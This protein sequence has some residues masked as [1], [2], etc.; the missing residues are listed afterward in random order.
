[1][2][3]KGDGEAGREWPGEAVDMG[4]GGEEILEWR[5]EAL[6]C[7]RQREWEECGWEELEM[8]EEEAMETKLMGA[9][10]M[11]AVEMGAK[12]ANGGTVMEET[13]V[14]AN[15]QKMEGNVGNGEDMRGGGDVEENVG[16]CVREDPKRKPLRGKRRVQKSI[17]EEG[18]VQMA[19]T[20]ERWLG[21]Q[22]I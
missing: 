8:V 14:R 7:K 2:A 22:P 12:E 9:E 15:E 18:R 21:N 13:N 20:M 6:R 17:R 11:S 3:Q 19:A 5:G 16:G 10:H 4:G 1:M